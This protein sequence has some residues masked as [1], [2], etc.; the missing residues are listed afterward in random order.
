MTGTPAKAEKAGGSEGVTSESGR[1][2]ATPSERPS[3]AF[4]MAKTQ[5]KGKDGQ[6]C[7]T[8]RKLR[9]PGLEN[10]RAL[11]FMVIRT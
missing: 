4:E 6:H 7:P 11:L 8:V 10:H 9:P 5:W 2:W 3:P 1:T